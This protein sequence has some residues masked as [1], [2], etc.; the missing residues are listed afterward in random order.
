MDQ[1]EPSAITLQEPDPDKMLLHSLS[2]L[3]IS[4][5]KI[6]KLEIERY[7]KKLSKGERQLAEE[8]ATE[9]IGKIINAFHMQLR[10]SSRKGDYNRMLGALT[11][12]FN[13]EGSTSYKAAQKSK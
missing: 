13:S 9:Y 3:R 2:H 6:R 4:L 10:A 1:I 7:V 5:E 8:F 11:E 12:L